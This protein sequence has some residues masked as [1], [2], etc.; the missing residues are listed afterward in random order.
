MNESSSNVSVLERPT[1]TKTLPAK[2]HSSWLIR[3]LPIF[4]ILLGLGGFAV[5]G[6]STN[7]T[8]PKFSFLTGTDATDK[9]DWCKEH[10]VPDSQC[11]VCKP[12]LSPTG[13]VFGWC[14]KHG[15]HECPLCH[16]EVAQLKTRPTQAELEPMRDRTR[17]A[18]K[19]IE[20]PEY[21]S[22]CKKHLRRI[23]FASE[24]A[25]SKAGVTID[26]VSLG[27]VV[28]TVSTNGEITYDQTRVA[29]LSSQ[30]PGKVW[31]VEKQV[32]SQ[33]KRG[34]ILAF[35]DAGEV[36]RAKAEF[37]QAF[38]QVDA[39]GRLLA[40]LRAAEGTIA[41]RVIQETEA[42]L[43]EARI[44][45][46]SAQQALVNLGLPIQADELKNLAEDKLGEKVQFLGIPENI[47]RTLNPR[48][49]SGNLLPVVSPVSGT[50]VAREAVAGEVVDAAK[51][52]FVVADT[53][54]MWLCLDVRLEDA[55]R[56]KQGQIVH[57]RPDGWATAGAVTLPWYQA[58][59][60]KLVWLQTIQGKIN[61]VNTGVDE[62]TRTVKVRVE[63]ANPDGN[64]RASTFG[65]GRIVL[66]EETAVVAP[67]EA[68]HWE[69][70]CH[71]VFVRDKD[72]LDKGARKVF[73]VRK[74]V[75]G[76]RDD[77][78]VEIVS[79]LLPGEVVAVKGSS[80][81][82]SELLKNDLGAG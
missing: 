2:Q 15:V 10:P 39:K 75:P 28:E 74:V 49:T 36:G 8:L 31:R 35:V 57:F 52:L 64:L 16:P 65:A 38:A 79:G 21:D 51:V 66:R 54:Q 68:L 41:G 25:V 76:A 29:R 53:R 27:P 23:Q 63:V 7:W 55:K 46:V 47:A 69:G 81:L 34:E 32:G 26:P 24:E 58:T 6:H 11:L 62:K 3:S 78:T 45:L 30:A 19:F 43:R 9:D 13:K 60:D 20:R 14:G 61:W 1:V 77:K 33:V 80:V 73:H 22:K 18:L 50:V 5:W 71:V 67:R 56:L 12:G 70:C 42:S 59:S 82:R 4:L 40:S 44:R 48:T 72:Y 37:L 17:R